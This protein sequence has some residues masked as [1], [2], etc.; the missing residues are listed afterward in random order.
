MI[1]DI[2]HDRIEQYLLGN[3]PPDECAQLE[4]EMKA[5]PQLAE[6]VALQRLAI[7]G[8]QRLAARDM[9]KKF[10]L[11]DKETDGVSPQYP[12]FWATLILL[13]LLVLGIFLH[14][15]KLR[16]KHEEHLRELEVI[17]ARDSLIAVLQADYRN[18]S[19]ALDSLSRN[20]IS[21]KDSL[22]KNE[23][24]QLRNRLELGDRVLRELE[25]QRNAGKSQM[26]MRLAPPPPRLRGNNQFSDSPVDRAKKAYNEGKY[27]QAVQLFRK[28]PA[29]D[30]AQ[31]QVIQHLPLA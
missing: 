2:L 30:P 3:L 1:D 21:E 5:N 10:E 15:S 24:L 23:L 26:A 8:I 19:T 25:R 14:F 20:S 9:R 18:L 12:W 28:I 13:G 27:D 31:A 22:L 6:Q 16:N 11:W 29:S 17:A 7:N 4:N